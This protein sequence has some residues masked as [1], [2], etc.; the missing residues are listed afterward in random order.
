MSKSDVQ[1]TV[2]AMKDGY[3]DAICAAI[4]PGASSTTEVCCS[5]HVVPPDFITLHS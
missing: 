2:C 3:L 1:T 5:L 4:V